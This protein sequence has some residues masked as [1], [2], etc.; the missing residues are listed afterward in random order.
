MFSMLESLGV[1][2]FEDLVSQ[3]R[4]G[5]IIK[6]TSSTYTTHIDYVTKV[7]IKEAVILMYAKVKKITRSEAFQIL[8]AYLKKLEKRDLE[9]IDDS[10]TTFKEMVLNSCKKRQ[11]FFDKLESRDEK[12]NL[13]RSQESIEVTAEELNG[14]KYNKGDSSRS[15]TQ[16]EDSGANEEKEIDGVNVKKGKRPIIV[17]LKKAF[18][19]QYAKC[20]ILGVVVDK[21]TTKEFHS[22]TESFQEECQGLGMIKLRDQ[23]SDEVVKIDVMGQR[24]LAEIFIGD[25]IL[26]KNLFFIKVEDGYGCLKDKSLIM[27]FSKLE[28][29][30]PQ[31]WSRFVQLRNLSKLCSLEIEKDPVWEKEYTPSE[32]NCC[33]ILDMG[34]YVCRVCNVCL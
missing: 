25:I 1:A 21:I 2:I 14:S 29:P 19:R 27:K 18:K 28:E 10:A 13:D 32:K 9:E 22:E 34:M 11:R 6:I 8:L 7:L 16:N 30:F 15:Q 20:N 4:I 33:S 17:P 24:I 5:S 31:E 3:K 23:T 12:E 26:I